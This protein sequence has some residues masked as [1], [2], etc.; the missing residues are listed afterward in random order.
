MS[1]ITFTD[2]DGLLS[3]Y[4]ARCVFS[5]FCFFFASVFLSY[6]ILKRKKIEQSDFY[7]LLHLSLLI[8]FFHSASTT[9]NIIP[10]P[11]LI[12]LI[13]SA[14]R[15]L[16]SVYG[17]DGCRFHRPRGDMQGCIHLLHQFRCISS[18]GYTPSPKKKKK[19]PKRKIVGKVK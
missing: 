4:A 16:F 6:S 11:L 8:F 7:S 19:R 9:G 10:F 15:V 3:R 14:G 13:Y 17:W 5:F 1:S 2:D 12:Y 18:D